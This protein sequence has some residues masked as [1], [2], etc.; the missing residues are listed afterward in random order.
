MQ[1]GDENATF[2][3]TVPGIWEFGL[4]WKMCSLAEKS[5]IWPPCLHSQPF[6]FLAGSRAQHMK[7]EIGQKSYMVE[8][9]T[10][11]RKQQVWGK[12]LTPL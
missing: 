2:I 3:P 4:N 12:D 9:P 10:D 6:T 8:L 5:R 11:G 7:Q 1:K